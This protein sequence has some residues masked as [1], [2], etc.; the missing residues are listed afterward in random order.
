M[1][2]S[3]GLSLCSKWKYDAVEP[4]FGASLF[5]TQVIRTDRALDQRLVE[6]VAVRL[7]VQKSIPL[8]AE[9]LQPDADGGSPELVC[10]GMACPI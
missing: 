10:S 5:T 9:D 7:V 1:G 4:D 3:F 8:N 2:A 6:S